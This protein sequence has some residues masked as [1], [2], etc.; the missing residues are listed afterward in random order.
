ME[1]ENKGTEPLPQVFILM[2]RGAEAGYSTLG[3]L[4]P[5][6]KLQV[7]LRELQGRF[8][9][10]SQIQSELG[11]GLEAA[12]SA[13]G[14]YPREAA[15][16]VNTWRDSWLAEQGVRALYLLPRA[17]TDRTL[18]L[19]VTPKPLQSERV[20]VGRAE[21]ITPEM[22]EKINGQL[23]AYIHG[24]KREKQNAVN[25][26]LTMGMGRFTEPGLRRALGK[27][28]T[29]QA[30]QS[31]DAFLAAV[32]EAQQRGAQ[33]PAGSKVSTHAPNN[34]ARILCPSAELTSAEFWAWLM[35]DC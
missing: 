28:P 10:L 29:P 9:P 19:D 12:L 13:E 23:Q 31:A 17:W 32:L 11:T 35:P 16:M 18:P 3:A 30:R 34:S 21:V 26:C 33:Q 4:Q 2:V 27:N 15:A 8:Q 22:V 6:Q 5:S 1:L 7:S 20:M 25:E 14:L 24:S